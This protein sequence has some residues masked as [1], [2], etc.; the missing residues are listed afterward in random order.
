MD[1]IS[2]VIETAGGVSALAA[3]L[4]VKPPTVYQWKSGDRPV[5][6]RLAL[7]IASEWPGLVTA[8]DLRPDVFGPAP[9]GEEAA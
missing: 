1:K 7:A 9:G 3:K 4:G 6:P 8:H 2:A 5:P